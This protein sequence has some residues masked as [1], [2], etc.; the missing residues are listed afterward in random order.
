LSNINNRIDIT[1]SSTELKEAK[2]LGKR[3]SKKEARFGRGFFDR[4]S[5]IGHTYGV[6]SEWGCAKLFG[7]DFDR[8]IFDDHGDDGFDL[9][10]P[11]TYSCEVKTT[12]YTIAPMLRVEVNKINEEIDIYIACCINR[13]TLQCWFFGWTEQ[14]YVKRAEKKQLRSDGPLNYILTERELRDPLELLIKVA[15]C[16][17]V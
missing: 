14:N 3:R 10:L 4:P 15:D 13:Y 2:T 9:V 1:L 12:S 5:V 7:I 17:E 11:G 16:V 6:V 8:R